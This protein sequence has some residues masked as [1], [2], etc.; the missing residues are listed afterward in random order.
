MLMSVHQAHVFTAV[1]LMVRISLLVTVRLAGQDLIV[2]QVKSSIHCDAVNINCMQ[3]T[4]IVMQLTL[5]VCSQ[6][7]L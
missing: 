2:I 7:S 1:V 5:I 4:F 6:H 3:S